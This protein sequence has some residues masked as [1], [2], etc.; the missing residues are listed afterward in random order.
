MFRR[1]A[2]NFNPNPAAGGPAVFALTPMQLARFLEQVWSGRNQLIFPQPTG[3][4][5]PAALQNQEA[6]S[7]VPLPPP[8]YVWKHLKYL[9]GMYE[10]EGTQLYVSRGT[11]MIGVPV[12]IGAR[13]E[14]AVLRLERA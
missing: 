2:A 14:V 10:S 1:L 3:L 11:G 4:E 9:R 7:G 13:P 12:R 5:V 8:P 6:A